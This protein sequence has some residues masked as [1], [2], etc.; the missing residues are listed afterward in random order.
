MTSY[1]TIRSGR[2]FF[3]APRVGSIAHTVTAL[4]TAAFA[5]LAQ[6]A[7]VDPLPSWNEGPAKARILA[8]VH[9][10]TD[11]SSK[12]FVPPAERIATFDNDGTL[13]CEQPI[14]VQMAF[15]LDRLDALAAT[16]PEWR[17]TQPYQA[18]LARDFKTLAAQGEQG[19]VKL[20]AATHA[21]M[22]SDEFDRIASDWIATA[23]HPRFERLYSELVFQPMLE[24]LAHL[25][26]N[27]FK[28]YIVSGG[29]IDFMRPW[30]ERVYGIPPEQVVG[31][32]GKLRYAMRDGQPTLM[33]LAQIDHVDDGPGK[34]VGIRRFIGRRPIAA[35][36]N[37]DG[38]LPML[39]YTAAAGQ[40]RLI[41]IVRHDD[42]QREYEYDRKSRVG[43][44]DK[45][46]D[47]AL[48]KGW[49]VVSMK[50]DWKRVFR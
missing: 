42:A 24:V 25:R 45:A 43:K 19:A 33:R 46:L 39:E 49:T 28:T 20:V 23:R 27:G 21:G 41:V 12:D 50:S 6:A 47:A 30:T 16:H 7:S 40:P 48:A 26:A 29:G 31:S 38:D 13:W 3:V 1:P 15:L 8:F 18:A 36:G 34:P 4:V 11:P 44:L 32:S 10:V 37:S 22:S 14:Y 9:A 35:F 17:S 5:T 2:S